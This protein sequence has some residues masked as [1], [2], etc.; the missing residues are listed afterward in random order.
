[1]YI[2]ISSRSIARTS[3]IKE[4]NIYTNFNNKQVIIN[5]DWPEFRPLEN[6]FFFYLSQFFK[7]LSCYQQIY[8]QIFLSLWLRIKHCWIRVLTIRF[9]GPW[10]GNYSMPRFSFN[11]VYDYV[12]QHKFPQSKYSEG[13]DRD[14]HKCQTLCSLG[15]KKQQMV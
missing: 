14:D 2:L 10:V 3:Y 9:S 1:M 15:I 6:S 4:F 13:R 12:P 8:K 11:I 5:P 7:V